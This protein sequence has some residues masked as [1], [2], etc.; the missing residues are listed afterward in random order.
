MSKENIVPIL[1]IGDVIDTLGG[2]ST[3]IFT[4]IIVYLITK[5]YGEETLQELTE[6][7]I[8]I[9]KQKEGIN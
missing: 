5:R 8:N 2:F 7:D 1:I 6:D 9:K 3:A 4:L